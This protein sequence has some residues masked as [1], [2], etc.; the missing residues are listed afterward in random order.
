MTIRIVRAGDP[1]W[2]DADVDVHRGFAPDLLERLARVKEREP[3]ASPWLH[4]PTELYSFGRCYREWTR[5][6]RW[7]PIPLYGDHGVV[8]ETRLER[9]ELESTARVHLTWS[10]PR[11]V[12]NADLAR[13]R[14]VLVQNPWVAFRHAHGIAPDPGRTGTLIVPGHSVPGIG[15]RVVDRA[16]AIRLREELAPDGPVVA[17]LHRFD[18][19]NGLHLELEAAGIP[20]VTAGNST[21]PRF[22][23]RFYG[24]VTRFARMWTEVAGSHV[25][26]AAELGIPVRVEPLRAF[27]GAPDPSRAPKAAALRSM[28]DGREPDADAAAM[29]ARVN[30]AFGPGGTES[31]RRDLVA[32]LLGVGRGLT[33]IALRRLMVRELLATA[34]TAAWPARRRLLRRIL[35][36]PTRALHRL[37]AAARAVS[38][39]A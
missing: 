1:L 36:R 26:Y 23:E 21:S 24:I 37:R 30:A 16:A 25:L 8:F 22:V 27:S 33:P 17:M 12:F 28:A 13:P 38:D 18:V 32:D 31:E 14:V 5:W 10:T 11:T 15:R 2:L 35:E 9:H 7:L 6:P 20:V 34:A 39:R 4:T 19:E 29:E 3:W